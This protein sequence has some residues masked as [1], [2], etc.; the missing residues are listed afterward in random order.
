VLFYR[1]FLDLRKSIAF[2]EGS[3]TSPVCPSG[4]SSMMMRADRWWGDIDG[5]KSKYSQINHCPGVTVF[6]TNLTGARTWAMV[7]TVQRL[8]S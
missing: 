1:M 5:E 8:T 3:Q 7:V 6:T 4:K 2:L